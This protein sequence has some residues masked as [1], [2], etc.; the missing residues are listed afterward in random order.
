MIEFCLLCAALSLSSCGSSTSAAT[1]F[2]GA[3][4]YQDLSEILAIGPR[5]AGSEAAGR[6]RSLIRGKLEA[7]GLRVE[8]HPFEA[9]TPLGPRNMVNLVAIVEGTLPGIIILGNHYDT[10]YFPDFEFVGANDGGSTTAWMIEM[11][12]ALGPT[13]DGYTVWLTWFDGEEALVEWSSLDSLYGSGTMVKRLVAENRLADVKAMINVDM[14][15]DCDLTILKDAGAPNWMTDIIWK[16]ARDLGYRKYFSV[17]SEGI[18]DD[19]LP[20]R[21]AGVQ[22]IGLIDFRYGGGRSEH[23]M[24]WHTVRDRI[25]RVCAESLQIVGDVVYHALGE[26][27]R[28]LAQ[29]DG[30]P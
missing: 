26:L 10:K 13:R 18:E 16:T 23:E 25:D 27:D 7:A 9:T 21:R 4:A 29:R 3:R 2:D 14:I 22:A 5:V 19:H 11:A 20:F 15:G 12:R 6:T 24:N 8:E 30:R 1:P 17:G 28:T